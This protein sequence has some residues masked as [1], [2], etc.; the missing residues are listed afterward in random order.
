M[1]FQLANGFEMQENEQGSFTLTKY[2]GFDMACME[3]PSQIDGKRVTAIGKSLLK[4]G[5]QLTHL[6]LRDGIEIIEDSAFEGCIELVK[7]EL[8]STLTK[9]GKR[10]FA[11]CM[12]SDITL[13]DGL[14]ALGASTFE[15]TLITKLVIPDSVTELAPFS[16]AGQDRLLEVSLPKNLTAIPE[17]A[18]QG[19]QNL[20]WIS[21]PP[22]IERIGDNAFQYAGIEAIDF[23]DTVKHI[24]KQAF[25]GAPIQ[26]LSI[27]A[28]VETV[29]E[30]SFA[31]CNL[32]HVYIMPGSRVQLETGVF[33]NNPVLS[34]L[35]IPAT[36]SQIENIFYGDIYKIVFVREAVKDEDGKAVRDAWGDVKEQE[37]LMSYS[38]KKN[39]VPHDLVA[40]CAIGSAFMEYARENGIPCAEYKDKEVVKLATE[41]RAT[42]N[43][44][45]QKA[46][47]VVADNFAASSERAR[48]AAEAVAAEFAAKI[49]K[50]KNAEFTL[51][52][53][54]HRTRPHLVTW[55]EEGVQRTAIISKTVKYIEFGAFSNVVG[56]I[57]F[58]EG[59]Q[60]EKISAYAFR[61]CFF[62][63]LLTLP[64]SVKVIEKGAFKNCQIK[65]I[66]VPSTCRVDEGAAEALLETLKP[67]IVY[68][69]PPK[70]A[71]AAGDA[72]QNTSFIKK[73]FGKFKS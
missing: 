14:Q 31:Y 59:S 28:G 9:I 55:S 19:C 46:A 47:E 29:E 44:R 21:L 39:E 50:Q 20:K 53:S 33:V 26:K 57:R 61:D 52:I 64:P 10:A 54:A 7:V 27:P 43:E 3:I 67:K 16:F 25:H 11:G 70:Q 69:D 65:K 48:K 17:G 73:L 37:N 66:R 32:Q 51:D 24:G 13:P 35:Y 49:E 40:Y 1:D 18:F 36:V 63:D 15:K 23:P 72:T 22:K 38:E 58:E 45:A 34:R 42:E 6:K 12:I 4:G 30:G 2:I 8:P 5:K 68:Y 56:D 62:G 71:S 41:A 60:L